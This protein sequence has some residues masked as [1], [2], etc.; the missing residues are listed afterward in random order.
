[1]SASIDAT[2]SGPDVKPQ[3]EQRRYQL[4]SFTSREATTQEKVQD[5]HENTRIA[6]SGNDASHDEAGQ[7]ML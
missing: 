6:S 5:D 3:P 2:A 7:K 4:V 1:M